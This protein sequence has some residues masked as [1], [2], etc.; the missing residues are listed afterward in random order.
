MIFPLQAAD[1]DNQDGDNKPK[2]KNNFDY[3]QHRDFNK[4]RLIL[5]KQLIRMIKPLYWK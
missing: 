5:K 3:S 4:F 2:I 1:K